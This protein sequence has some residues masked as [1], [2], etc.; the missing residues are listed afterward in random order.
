VGLAYNKLSGSIDWLI[1]KAVLPALTVC[2]IRDNEFTGTI[3]GKLPLQLAV[4]DADSNNFSAIDQAIC[5][6]PVPAFGN[7]GG[8]TSDWPN[9]PFGTCC[10]SNNIVS[11]RSY[12]NCTSSLPSCVVNN[13][14][15]CIISLVPEEL[16]AWQDLYDATNGSKWSSCSDAR[17]DPCACG[18][19]GCTAGHI[20]YM[21]LATNN[22]RGTIPSSLAKL[23]KMT[24]LTLNNNRL[25]GLVPSLPFAQYTD[26]YGGECVLDN[27]TGCTEPNCNHFKCPLPA[28]SE[29][30]KDASVSGPGVHC[31]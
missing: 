9:Q 26:R 11:N 5:T 4:F 16:S 28:G 27:P 2:F 13:C 19:V 21:V 31:K 17:S 12:S 14:G 24:T 23:S 8:C 30:C 29:Q 15:A 6:S 20:T 1:T 10:L 3:G 7:A 18:G 22:L 25:T